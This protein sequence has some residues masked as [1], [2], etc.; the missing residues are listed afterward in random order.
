[1]VAA[2]I[3]SSRI[4]GEGGAGRARFS[5]G[6]AGRTV[7]ALGSVAL[8]FGVWFGLAEPA[9]LARA[10][11][12]G[13]LNIV[14]PSPL[15]EQ[16]RMLERSARL[17]PLDDRTQA[18]LSHL[19]SRVRN[20]IRAERMRGA[21]P[22]GEDAPTL[23]KVTRHAERAAELSPRVSAHHRRL[24]EVYLEGYGLTGLPDMLK[25]AHRETRL[26]VRLFP[27]KPVLYVALARISELDGQP[28]GALRL[29]RKALELTRNQ[30]HGRNRLS[31]EE[32]KAVRRRVGELEAQ[33]GAH[34]RGS[35]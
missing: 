7:L 18:C 6:S 13:A 19:Y 29:Y 1:M 26:A 24:A 35:K 5:L 3:V 21:A 9:I 12:E 32:T 16:R 11:R 34:P 31:E 15:D 2:L 27:S 23:A 30:A 28:G 22:P 8:A 33:L 10:L 25:K 17:D 4:G 20:R 14:S